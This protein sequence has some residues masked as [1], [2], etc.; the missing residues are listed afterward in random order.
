MFKSFLKFALIMM[1]AQAITYYFAGIIAQNVLGA[2]DFYPPS[3]TA[4]TYLKD[5]RDP[6]VQ[7]WIL[8]AQLLRGLLFA[9]VLFPFRKQILESG[10]WRGGLLIAGFIFIAG[11]VAAS[12]GMVEH[13]VFF[14]AE[15]YPVRFAFISFFEILIQTAIMG[16][17]VV[18]M[19]R[20]YDPVNQ[21][22]KQPA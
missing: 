6:G 18:F 8:P 12:G 11:Y 2:H 16:P 13:F 15:D 1:V 5:P 22:P 14:K 19:D 20:K 9:L 7:L 10:I 17:A 21:P 4:I 3:A